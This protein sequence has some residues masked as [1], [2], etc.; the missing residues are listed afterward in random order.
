MTHTILLLSSWCVHTARKKLFKVKRLTYGL[1]FRH[2]EKKTMCPRLYDY[3][4]IVLFLSV[5]FWNYNALNCARW[6]NYCCTRPRTQRPRIVA[7]LRPQNKGIAEPCSLDKRHD[8]RA[9][10]DKRT[11]NFFF[12]VVSNR[13]TIKTTS[14]RYRIRLNTACSFDTISKTTGGFHLCIWRFVLFFFII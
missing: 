3:T 2:D 12:C 11:F 14:I 7:R 6:T 9:V 13:R 1:N 4:I 5:S 8:R 10:H